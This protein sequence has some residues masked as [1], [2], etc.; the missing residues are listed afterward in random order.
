MKDINERIE[1]LRNFNFPRWEDLPDKPVFGKNVIF[2][3]NSSLAGL[4]P[5]KDHLTQN[6]I[7]N[8]SKWNLIPKIEGRKYKKEHIAYL[9]VITAFKELI[10]ISDVYCGVKLMV[11]QFSGEQAYNIFADIFE[12]AIRRTFSHAK[13]HGVYT[14]EGFEIDTNVAGIKILSNA[15]ALRLLGQMVLEHGGFDLLGE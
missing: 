4:I 1:L 6:M 14:F 9:M 12:K 2:F 15:F 11:S 5:E 10:N 13:D 8:Y 3:V 7:Q